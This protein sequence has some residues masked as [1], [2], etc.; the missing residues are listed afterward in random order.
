MDWIIAL[1]AFVLGFITAVLAMRG[2]ERGTP[3]GQI[4]ECVSVVWCS[5]C[6]MPQSAL[7]QTHKLP[8]GVVQ[9]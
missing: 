3:V 2:R 7:C 6:G 5:H 9:P 1:P 4:R 8:A